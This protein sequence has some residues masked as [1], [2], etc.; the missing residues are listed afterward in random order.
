MPTDLLT[1]KGL[2]Y[3]LDNLLSGGRIQKITQPEADEI[4]LEIKNNGER[5]TLVISANAVA[6]RC[7]LTSD[8]KDNP[9]TAPAFCMHLRKY[10]LSAEIK[11]ISLSNDDRIFRFDL[12]GRDEL[13]ENKTYSLFFEQMSRY[14]NIIL[15]LSN[16]KISD[17]LHRVNL[18][19]NAK[20]IL[21]PTAKYEFPEKGNRA[22]LY[23]YEKIFEYLLHTTETDAQQAVLK[24]I[25]G[26]SKLSAE[27]LVFRSKLSYPYDENGINRFIETLTYFNSIFEKSLQKPSV[28][29]NFDDFFVT[30]YECLNDVK[31][32]SCPTLNQAAE[33]HFFRC[34]RKSRI[35]TSSK[36]ILVV[37]KR[38]RDKIVKKISFAKDK[39]TECENM[40]NIK[41]FGELLT[42]NL[43]KLKK[44][45]KSVEVENYYDNYSPVTIALDE[46]KT[47]QQNA[48]AYYN[49]YSKLKRAEAFARQQLEEYTVQLDY[50]ESIVEELSRA[51]TTDIPDIKTELMNLGIIK[52]QLPQKGAKRPLPAQPK[53]FEISGYKVYVGT[54]NVLNNTV[55]FDIGRSYDI[56]LH[57]KNHHGSH[58][59]IYKNQENDSVPEEVISKVA[60]IAAFYSSAR[61]SQNVAV[62]YTERR[63]VKRCKGA[64]LGMVNYQ[65]YKTV[66]VNPSEKP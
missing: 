61:L 35:Q 22:E 66:Y 15:T 8:K 21:I 42:S 9:Q 10:L 51:D 46:K 59:I 37:A 28:L 14:S 45:D 13:R 58:A 18:E 34:D 56:W 19:E 47:P 1:L 24:S 41:L 57:V 29:S 2:A 33:Q 63:N 38:H 7:H 12:E 44:G 31:Y 54:N 17:C 64:G 43:Y 53:E 23:E 6:P 55:T 11:K 16:G 39:L 30:P 25:N 52:K 49:K 27:E 60:A 4:R 48:A 5:Y 65:N 32:I 26:L 40:E 36:D 50:I 62:D 3:E 20:R